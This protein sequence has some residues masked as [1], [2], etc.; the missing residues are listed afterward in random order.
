M[1]RTFIWFVVIQFSRFLLSLDSF[2]SLHRNR[3]VVNSFFHLFLHFQGQS[4]SADSWQS[5]TPER[6][7]FPHAAIDGFQMHTLPFFH[8]AG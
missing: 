8:L 3:T 2:Y 5:L 4:P 7:Q 6:K 1:T